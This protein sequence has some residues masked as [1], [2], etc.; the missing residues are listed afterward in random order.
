M[1]NNETTR[2]LVLKVFGVLDKAVSGETVS[3]SH[4][5]SFRTGLIE[6]ETAGIA[7][8]NTRIYTERIRKRP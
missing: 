2:Y 8:G 5:L 3:Q 1:Q 6:R 7:A 4:I